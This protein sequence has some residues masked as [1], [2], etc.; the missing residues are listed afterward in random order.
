MLCYRIGHSAGGHFLSRLTGFVSTGAERIVVANPGGHLFPTRD[1]SFPYGFGKL[2]AAL[3]EDAALQ[4]YFA[5]LA[6]FGVRRLIAALSLLQSGD[7]SPHSKAPPDLNFR[8][9]H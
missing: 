2:T 6:N 7:K 3:S 4:H 9:P 5:Q 8:S 1:M